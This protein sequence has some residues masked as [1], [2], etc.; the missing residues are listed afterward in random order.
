MSNKGLLIWDTIYAEK[1]IKYCGQQTKIPTD[2]HYKKVKWLNSAKYS[3]HSSWRF[4][5]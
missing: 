2:F 4:E 3:I 5:I 1:I